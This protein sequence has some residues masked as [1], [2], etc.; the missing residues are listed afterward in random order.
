MLS[1][2]S[3]YNDFILTFTNYYNT[4]KRLGVS[5]INMRILQKSVILKQKSEIGKYNVFS[6]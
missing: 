3:E 2:K 1:H 4:N 5:L 6:F